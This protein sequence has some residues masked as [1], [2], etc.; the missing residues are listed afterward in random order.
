MRT[1][2]FLSLAAAA[3]L[4]FCPAQAQQAL[5][6]VK[7]GVNFANISSDVPDYSSDMRTG[8]HIGGGVNFVISDN[9]SITAD[10]LY[11]MKGAKQ[12]TEYIQ[13]NNSV[14]ITGTVE[15]KISLS[16]IEVPVL[17]RYKLESGIY[18]NGGFYFGFLASYKDEY[19][20]TQ[21]VN[22]GNNINTSSESGSTTDHSDISSA[23]AGLKFGLGYEFESGLD[24]GLNYS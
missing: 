20:V 3:F 5:F 6:G 22:N 2:Y 4:F 16:Y 23:D 17:A 13:I 10:L 14:T 1:K 9:F 21:T 24:V 12:E 11:T 19:T 15:E 8:L 18:F 7:A